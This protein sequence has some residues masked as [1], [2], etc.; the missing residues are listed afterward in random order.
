MIAL[1]P[2]TYRR[3][4]QRRPAKRSESLSDAVRLPGVIHSGPV[5]MQIDQQGFHL[6]SDRADIVGYLYDPTSRT[7]PAAMGAAPGAPAAASFGG[8]AAAPP[9]FSR[10]R[11][12]L[13]V[14]GLSSAGDLEER[15][16]VPEPPGVS[17]GRSAAYPT[18]FFAA[19]R[20]LQKMLPE[21]LQLPDF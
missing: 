19:Q 4:H 16:L 11:L 20:Q 13:R 8:P 21:R 18:S 3:P 6:P 17:A 10:W 2:F 12:G 9:S 7:M 1:L 15:T 14:D 5:W